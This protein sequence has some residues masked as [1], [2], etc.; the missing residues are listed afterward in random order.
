MFSK[1]FNINRTLIMYLQN[2]SK[3][4]EITEKYD[5]IICDIWGVLHNGVAIYQD[6]IAALRKARAKGKYIILLTN[7]PKRS[8]IIN[9][10]FKKMGVADIFYDKTF[11]SGDCIS[12]YLYDYALDKNIFHW[13]EEHDK[14]IYSEHSF[15]LTS[16]EDAE[17]VICTGLM[18][19]KTEITAKELSM[20]NYVADRK[21][22]FICAN[23]DKSVRIGNGFEL[24]AGTLADIYQHQFNQ[25]VDFIGKPYP[26][27]YHYC[28]SYIQEFLQADFSVDKILAIGDGLYTDIKGAS[29]A[30]IDCLF[31]VN[32]LHQELFNVPQEHQ[33][34]KIRETC[35]AFDVCPEYYIDYLK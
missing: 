21:L 15:Q 30:Q 11:T 23:P 1:N 3:L 12:Q 22:P 16:L 24:C 33:F 8:D 34:T 31:V 9:D 35:E 17:I 10:R 2:I 20:L 5:A 4:D 14:G 19:K 6:A 28:F 7:A 29:N 13:G 32:G 18:D 27:A 25:S 26:I